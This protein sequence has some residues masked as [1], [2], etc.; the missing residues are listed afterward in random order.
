[1]AFEKDICSEEPNKTLNFIKIIFTFLI[2]CFFGNRAETL[3][4]KKYKL[5]IIR[6]ILKVNT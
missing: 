4:R 2:C 3:I 1:M 5:K 6:K